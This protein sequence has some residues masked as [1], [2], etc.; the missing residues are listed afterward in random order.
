MLQETPHGQSKFLNYEDLE[1]PDFESQEI[2]LW[3]GREWL[4]SIPVKDVIN[5]HLGPGTM[6]CLRSAPPPKER[7]AAPSSY[8]YELRRLKTTTTGPTKHKKPPKPRRPGA[9]RVYLDAFVNA[10]HLQHA[11]E[12]AY[13]LLHPSSWP[14]HIPVEFHIKAHPQ[15]QL[16]GLS[17]FTRG[18]VDLHPAVILRALPEGAFQALKPKVDGRVEA[19]WVVAPSRLSHLGGVQL[20]PISDVPSMLEKVVIKKK[21]WLRELIDA[22]N[23]TPNGK[24]LTKKEKFQRFGLGK[25]SLEAQGKVEEIDETPKEPDNGQ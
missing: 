10:S 23:L 3:S 8:N 21:E 11:L 4:G 14:K 2:S 12:T 22:G 1:V 15:P 5:D 9:M 18:R 20:P 25:Q 16:S 17:L 24:L 6:L 7:L 19:L 13:R